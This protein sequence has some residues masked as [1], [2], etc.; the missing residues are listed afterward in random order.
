MK[1]IL[2]SIL[3]VATIASVMLFPT[4]A[5]NNSV[6]QEVDVLYFS[7]KPTF[8]GVI[9]ADE[10][11][12]KS[13]TVSGADAAKPGD[14]APAATNTFA[15]YEHKYD[16]VTKV[17]SEIDEVNKAKND[18]ITYDVWLRWDA[19]YFYMAA[20]VKDPDGYYLPA[21]RERI[22]DGDC[23]QFRVDPMG[24]NGYLS[25]KNPEYNY[26]TDG[27]DVTASSGV[28]YAPW[29]YGTKTCN[30][31]M[32]LVNGDRSNSRNL[33][34]YDM[35]DQGTGNMTKQQLLNDPKKMGP[36]VNP[37]KDANNYAA[38]F[39]MKT[40]D[41]NGDGYTTY[42]VAIPWCFIDQWGLGQ[43]AVGYAWGMSAVYLNGFDD[44]NASTSPY[45]SYVTWGTGICGAQQ[46]QAHLRPTLGG[47]NAIIL[48]DVDALSGAKVDG[49][50]QYQEPNPDDQAAVEYKVIQA[51]GMNA[52]YLGCPEEI[53]TTNGDFELSLDI[54]YLGTDPINPDR[55]YIGTWLGDGYS[56]AAG[57]HAQTKKF[58]VAQHGFQNGISD[59]IT[60]GIPY[61]QSEEEFDWQVGDWHNMTIRIVDETVTISLDGE[62]VLEDTDSRN[63]CTATTAFY[64]TIVYNIG[65]YVYDNYTLT[66]NIGEENEK[67]V[68]Y[69][70]DSDDAEFN[71]SDFQL[72]AIPM[73]HSF[74]KGECKIA[75]PE[76]KY[77]C[78]MHPA[79]NA[80]GKAVMKCDYCGTE[81][82]PAYTAG[83]VNSDCNINLS[84]VSM[85]LQAI[86]KWEIEGYTAEAADV[87]A[88]G[89]VT[90][91][92][93]SKM[94]QYIAKWEGVVLG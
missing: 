42:E 91:S 9:N 81:Y 80:D 38:E 22:W 4:S 55:T 27:Y 84:D 65:D 36:D 62:V 46:D 40:C 54:A 2:S 57:W 12:E 48:S 79:V 17:I 86:A 19:E 21:G 32:G 78:L 70:C 83:D 64:S 63:K 52:Y 77:N 76:S 69:T 82:A 33:Q 30:I 1:R 60:N 89:S 92:D 88:D 66:I 10:W 43:V 56:M 71:K 18:L 35:A 8:D 49:L 72:N 44:G 90:L 39:G 5:E 41:E 47:S 7:Q 34:V 6:T 50:P 93:V 13:F 31:G 45:M 59:T 73:F 23:F 85:M 87:N 51:T 20:K 15:F 14:A 29:A 11:G 94:L 67:T 24:P 28:N 61:S 75:N 16:A 74:V 37:L 68:A 53:A 25:Y 26:K 3:A 58:F